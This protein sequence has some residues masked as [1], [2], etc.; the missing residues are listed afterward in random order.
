[1]H[2]GRD[3]CKKLIEELQSA[4]ALEQDGQQKEFQ[5][6]RIRVDELRQ[7][8]YDKFVQEDRLYEILNS[9]EGKTVSGTLDL[10][11]KVNSVLLY[12][13]SNSWIICS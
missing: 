1:M 13:R 7:M 4:Q 11:S 9:L 6:E 10:L 3:R 8:Q 2:E 5:N 12:H